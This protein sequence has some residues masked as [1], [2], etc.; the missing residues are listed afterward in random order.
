MASWITNIQPSAGSGNATVT[1]SMQNNS[2]A[3]RTATIR[4][5]GQDV[6][7][8]T[9]TLTQQAVSLYPIQLYART[10]SVQPYEGAA[11][12]DAAMNNTYTVNAYA[13]QPENNIG[14]GTIFYT[15]STAIAPMDGGGTWYRVGSSDIAVM[16]DAGGYYVQSVD[17]S[18]FISLP[19]NVSFSASG[20]SKQVNVTSN[21]SWIVSSKPSWVTISNGSG[22]GNGSFTATAT[23]NTGNS[24]SGSITVRSSDGLRTVTMTASQA[25]AAASAGV[26]PSDIQAVA[27]GGSYYVEVRASG[28]QNWTVN[29]PPFLPLGFTVTPMSGTGTNMNVRIDVPQNLFSN[30]VIH[31]FDVNIG[32]TN[33][34]VTIN[35]AGQPF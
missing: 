6:P 2:G 11:D 22:S 23:Q 8:K 20:E 27:Q 35:Q 7:D 5:K 32:G 18:Q 13:T 28:G 14:I 9:F 31:T 17:T 29:L 19:S 34:L 25:A 3:Q 10:S 16:I 24:R 33:Y 1:V 26:F 4:V 21:T 12:P 30:P 15:S